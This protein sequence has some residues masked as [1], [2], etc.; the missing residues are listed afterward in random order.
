M[1]NEKLI[2]D[3][4]KL[5]Y[6]H[7]QRAERHWLG[8]HIVKYP[9]DMLIYHMIMHDKRP[10][11]L[12]ET[13]TYLAGGTLFFASMFELIGHGHVITV[14]KR[15]ELKKRQPAHPRVT[16]LCGGSTSDEVLGAMKDAVGDGS[17][18]AVLDSTHKQ[19]H[20]KRE[21]MAYS[22]MVTPGQYL[23]LEDGYLNG[24]PV[25]PDYGPGPYEAAEW[26]MQ[27]TSDFVQEP[28]QDVFLITMNPNGW[29]RKKTPQER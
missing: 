27:Q 2:H 11:F 16:Y 8:Q 5:F 9:T 19:W 24:H 18:M 26:F 25:K 1:S 7:W 17:V 22:K 20:C 28:L 10:D 21:L 14:D 3:F 13:G 29:L 12:L 15:P 23:V 4:G 6:E